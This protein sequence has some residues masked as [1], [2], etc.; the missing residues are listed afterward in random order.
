[1]LR[2]TVMTL[3]FLG[4]AVCRSGTALAQ[5]GAAP[6]DSGDTAFVLISAA[7]VLFMTVGLAFFYGGLVRRKNV[8]SIMTQCVFMMGAIGIQWVLFGYTLS[9]GPDKGGLIGGLEWIGLRGVGLTPNADYGPTVP[10]QAFMIYQA[11]FAIITPAL[12]I[13][14]FAERMKF[15]GFCVFSI[16]WAFL[17]Y[18]PICHWIWGVGGFLRNL[19]VLDFAGGAVVHINAGIAALA[20]ALVLGKRSG[21]PDRTIPPH[22]LPF[23]MLGAGMLWFGWFGFNAGS[24]LAANGL[25]TSA[26]VVTNTAAAA[27]T[28]TWMGLEW[29]NGAGKPTM[30]GMATGAVAGLAT[31]TPAAGFVS[32]VAAI[33]IGAAA[34]VVCYFMVAYVKERFSYDDSLDAFGVHGVG[35][36]IGMIATG[37]FASK[38]I[39]PAGAN[40]LLFGNPKQLGIQLIGVAVTTVY[41]LA[42]TFVIFKV[43]NLI[44]GLRAGEDEERIGLDL[45]Q[46]N[47]AGYTVLD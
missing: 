28:L 8:L 3:I 22:N 19:G 25:A 15:G 21:Y 40:G 5:S 26:F 46:H 33:I 43:V 10:H 37:L 35:G 47:E 4:T 18:D 44:F 45:T 38:A 2:K 13:G 9:F 17:V 41:S 6:V 23:T 12:I 34:S 27:A 42:A 31:I 11:M 36:A 30:L 24:A 39:N 14:A 29:A 32:P 1:M 20:A 16:L 7:L